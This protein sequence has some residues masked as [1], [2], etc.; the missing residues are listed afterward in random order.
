MLKQRLHHL[1]RPRLPAPRALYS[2][3]L[4]V[5]RTAS[6]GVQMSMTPACYMMNSKYVCAVSGAKQ[7]VRGRASFSAQ[8]R[9]RGPGARLGTSNLAREL[10]STRNHRSL[11][12]MG[13][14]GIEDA[15]M[16][17]QPYH[18]HTSYF[19]VAVPSTRTCY[20]RQRV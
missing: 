1:Q 4:V 17:I 14:S 18:D 13:A 20:P 16:W 10:R 7:L 11:V 6:I 5:P 2:H 8:N 19:Q 12:L 3:C 9:L 15:G